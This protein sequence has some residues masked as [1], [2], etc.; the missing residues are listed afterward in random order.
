MEAPE[1]VQAQAPTYAP[2]YMYVPEF[3]AREQ[4]EVVAPRE[5]GEARAFEAVR[6]TGVLYVEPPSYEL[7]YLPV[8]EFMTREQPIGVPGEEKEALVP[9]EPRPAKMLSMPSTGYEMELPW[10]AGIVTKPAAEVPEKEKEPPVK[11][12]TMETPEYVQA[13]PPTYAPEYMYVPEFMARLQ[14]EVAAPREVEEARV[15]EVVRPTGV[16]Y[17]EPPSY[18]LEYLHVPEFMMREQPI[19]VPVQE[20]EAPA[21][22]AE[23]RAKEL[24]IP[25]FGYDVGFPVIADFAT[26][27]TVEV[28][29]TQIGKISEYHIAVDLAKK[30]SSIEYSGTDSTSFRDATVPE[31]VYSGTAL[32]PHVSTSSETTPAFE[33]AESAFM[34]TLKQKYATVDVPGDSSSC[35]STSSLGARRVEEREIAMWSADQQASTQ[36]AISTSGFQVPVTVETKTDRR[37]SLQEDVANGLFHYSRFTDA[38][39][40]A[41][42]LCDA[43]LEKIKLEFGRL[44]FPPEQQQLS[45]AAGKARR[46]SS[47]SDFSSLS[48][49]ADAITRRLLRDVTTV[50]RFQQVVPSMNQYEPPDEAPSQTSSEGQKKANG[51]RCN[52]DVLTTEKVTRMEER[53]EYIEPIQSEDFSTGTSRPNSDDEKSKSTD[54]ITTTIVLKNEKEEDMRYAELMPLICFKGGE[55]S[56]SAACPKESHSQEASKCPPD[57]DEEQFITTNVKMETRVKEKFQVVKPMKPVKKRNTTDADAQSK[58]LVKSSIR[59]EITLK[60][61]LH[62]AE[63]RRLEVTKAEMIAS[64]RPEPSVAEEEAVKLIPIVAEQRQVQPSSQKRTR[65]PGSRPLDRDFADEL[66]SVDELELSLHPPMSIGSPQR[67][68]DASTVMQAVDMA[69]GIPSAEETEVVKTHYSLNPKSLAPRRTKIVEMSV[70]HSVS[71]APSVEEAD[72]P[73]TPQPSTEEALRSRVDSVHTW[74]RQS[75]KPTPSSSAAS[76]ARKP[77]APEDEYSSLPFMSHTFES[78]LEMVPSVEAAPKESSASLSPLSAVPQPE[79]KETALAEHEGRQ[80]LEQE[81]LKP[82]EQENADQEKLHS[83]F[84][85]KK[86]F[87]DDRRLSVKHGYKEITVSEDSQPPEQPQM[88]EVPLIVRPSS[89]TY[90]LLE[91]TATLD[92]MQPIPTLEPEPAPYPQVASPDVRRTYNIIDVTTVEEPVEQ[93]EEVVLEPVSVR[94]DS[95]GY[96]IYNREGSV[97]EPLTA[98]EQEVVAEA[99]PKSDTASLGADESL[100]IEQFDKDSVGSEDN[101]PQELQIP[102]AP[103]TL[104]PSSPTY[105][106]IEDVASP[107]S[108]VTEPNLQPEP[109]LP[110][111]MPSQEVHQ[112]YKIIDIPAKEEAL[113]QPEELVP[114]SFTSPE[115]RNTSMAQTFK[116]FDKDAKSEQKEDQEDAY[117]LPEV[118]LSSSDTKHKTFKLLGQAKPTASKPPPVAPQARPLQYELEYLYVPDFMKQE[119]SPKTPTSDFSGKVSPESTLER[120]Y[121]PDY[122]TTAAPA[123]GPLAPVTPSTYEQPQEYALE[124][125]YVPDFMRSEAPALTREQGLN[126]QT[127]EMELSLPAYPIS[128]E[129][130]SGSTVIL[131]ETTPQEAGSGFEQSTEYTTEERQMRFAKAPSEKEHPAPS[132]HASSIASGVGQ[133]QPPKY[134]AEYLY[135][136]D[137]MKSEVL[138]EGAGGSNIT[139]PYKKKARAPPDEDVARAPVTY[140][141]QFEG[142]FS[143]S[144]VTQES[145][146][147]LQAP[148]VMASIEQPPSY[149]QQ[150]V[151][152]PESVRVPCREA[153]GSA[154]QSSKDITASDVQ[155]PEYELGY[156]YVPEFMTTEA[157]VESVL[158]PIHP[159]NVISDLSRLH[160]QEFSNIEQPE[161]NINEMTGHGATIATAAAAYEE[162]T[163]YDRRYEF[164]SMTAEAPAGDFQVAET[165]RLLPREHESEAEN[166]KSTSPAQDTFATESSFTFPD[167]SFAPESSD[168]YRPVFEKP[169]AGPP[170]DT[171]EAPVFTIETRPSTSAAEKQPGDEF[172]EVTST[173]LFAT[174]AHSLATVAS[175]E[176]EPAMKSLKLTE[177]SPITSVESL[178]PAPA[179]TEPGLEGMQKSQNYESLQH[180]DGLQSIEKRDHDSAAE[181]ALEFKRSVKPQEK[182]HGTLLSTLEEDAR[183]KGPGFQAVNKQLGE[184]SVD[185]S[186]DEAF[187]SAITDFRPAGAEKSAHDVQSGENVGPELKPLTQTRGVESSETTSEEMFLS[188]ARDEHERDHDDG[189]QNQAVAEPSAGTTEELSLP[190]SEPASLRVS[191][192]VES[193]FET[194][195][196][197]SAKASA[198]MTSQEEHSPATMDE[199]GGSHRPSMDLQSAAEPSVAPKEFSLPAS[200]AAHQKDEVRSQVVQ[201]TQASALE[202]ASAHGSAEAAAAHYQTLAKSSDLEETSLYPSEQAYE[203]SE[204]KRVPESFPQH[205]LFAAPLAKSEDGSVPSSEAARQQ[206]E[207]LQPEVEVIVQPPGEGSTD[208]TSEEVLFPKSGG[209]GGPFEI[210]P[211]EPPVAEQLVEIEE[212][213]VPTSELTYQPSERVEAASEATMKPSSEEPVEKTSEES[214]AVQYAS[215]VTV[216]QAHQPP[217]EHLVETKKLSVPATERARQAREKEQTEV[218]ILTKPSAVQPSEL[219]FGGAF[220]APETHPPYQ[221]F[222]KTSEPT[223]EPEYTLVPESEYSVSLAEAARETSGPTVKNLEGWSRSESAGRT[224]EKIM[225]R[226]TRQEQGTSDSEM[227]AAGQAEYSED[228]SVFPTETTLQSSLNAQGESEAIPEAIA[229]KTPERTLEGSFAPTT[230]QGALPPEGTAIEHRSSIGMTLEVPPEI[231]AQ[232]MAP[233]P[234]KLWSELR[235][236]EARSESSLL[237]TTKSGRQ[238]NDLAA[239]PYKSVSESYFASLPGLQAP[240]TRTEDAVTIEPSE[241]RTLEHG[242]IME[243]VVAPDFAP[244]V[245]HAVP[246]S[247][248]PLPDIAA[249]ASADAKQPVVAVQEGVAY[250]ALSYPDDGDL[251]AVFGD[252]DFLTPLATIDAE[253]HT[254]IGGFPQDTLVPVPPMECS[255]CMA[256]EAQPPEPLIQLSEGSPCGMSPVDWL[257]VEAFPGPSTAPV[258]IS[259]LGVPA[260]VESSMGEDPSM[261]PGEKET[262]R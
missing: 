6:P 262:S 183:Q 105:H 111:R 44:P 174:A 142:K 171:S 54:F 228:V 27:S 227:R 181:T 211:Q 92:T 39:G 99:A 35:K 137:F 216:R 164:D 69:D 176:Y 203:L 87:R 47:S 1:Y 158:A 166:I 90:T 254:L 179:E 48:I 215:E 74:R 132:E 204:N 140:E 144:V 130:L 259:Q 73:I 230:K 208:L 72:F 206:H 154:S 59:N 26:K 213:S 212:T 7:E 113:D 16:L 11:V 225:P 46:S 222:V 37:S 138:S 45:G 109:P 129:K 104:H 114:D 231:A 200:E 178:H 51:H 258:E 19:G 233:P 252:I 17:V 147:G 29:Q 240:K 112:T 169:T 221:H 150:Y 49:H 175:T 202:S 40:K 75:E 123:G 145:P 226:R 167:Y 242:P 23:T 251:F 245:E 255:P 180:E 168:E 151:Y 229:Q 71:D 36:A 160:D 58:K 159:T 86:T 249:L 238:E 143:H 43:E 61:F 76:E 190:S 152:V 82:P 125:I 67:K 60:Q 184:G 261:S 194:A 3:M 189:L 149:L 64:L 218:E 156:L 197:P 91:E 182:L 117:L 165:E 185:G 223:T 81:P 127:S 38:F 28:P 237:A 219:A 217:A 21:P 163:K 250:A 162:T 133:A 139:V 30:T 102:E 235:T 146:A 101:Q 63:H 103:V 244:S 8:P 80:G 115:I 248:R 153:P 136:P 257:V 173:E 85:S 193:D 260:S 32:A 53:L 243:A 83:E 5:V 232:E 118:K 4:P 198:E 94:R 191:K 50:E 210:G 253:L 256:A 187:S 78:Q 195:T 34:E 157:P 205:E 24:A 12:P 192:K 106:L 201:I 116:T 177:E 98:I 246:P 79:V 107:D 170:Q 57:S 33:S 239:L 135:V 62:E 9:E 141:Q 77:P 70:L 65:S 10:V 31:Q 56:N 97:Q 68:I 126:L 161:P 66:P 196:Q 108:A 93:R 15:F 214:L 95:T 199:Y 186:S 122:T 209:Y 14:P 20:K 247:Q 220:A 134:E 2:E 128:P 100:L 148:T 84:S 155:P 88:P 120:V 42:A 188:A 124:Y 131:A 121:T 41:E 234:R 241:L 236:E 172:A 96:Q 18:E 119:T 207:G 89:P 13:Q 224:S 25:P 55:P 110:P 52:F 22:E